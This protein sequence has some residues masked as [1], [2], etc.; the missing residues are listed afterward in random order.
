VASQ[1]AP[2]RQAF[3]IVSPEVRVLS[4]AWAW[5]IVIGEYDVDLLTSSS[6]FR[7][8]IGMVRLILLQ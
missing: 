1:F 3:S 8:E 4:Q 7:S 6:L 5:G 2:M